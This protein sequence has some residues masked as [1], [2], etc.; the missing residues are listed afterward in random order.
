M[1][2]ENLLEVLMSQKFIKAEKMGD[3]LSPQI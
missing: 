3:A 2:S 1:R